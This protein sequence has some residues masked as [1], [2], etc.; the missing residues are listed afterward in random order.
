MCTFWLACWASILMR[1]SRLTC[2]SISPHTDPGADASLCG[3]AATGASGTNAVR[4]GF[5]SFDQ[6]VILSSPRLWIKL[7]PSRA[8]ENC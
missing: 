2:E 7:F 1:P 8:H 5:H 6:H 3:M 4:C